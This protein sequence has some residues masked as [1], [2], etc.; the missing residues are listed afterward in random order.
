[1]VIGGGFT[2]WEGGS[3]V[4]AGDGD[5]LRHPQA[6]ALQFVDDGGTHLIADREHRG[7]ARILLQQLVDACG[8][9]F[10]EEAADGGSSA[11]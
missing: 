9:A 7:Q 2:W 8:A 3:V 1:M 10:V 6:A 5:F 4:E 11:F